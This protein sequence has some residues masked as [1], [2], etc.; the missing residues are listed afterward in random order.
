MKTG[1]TLTSIEMLKCLQVNLRK[2]RTAT[3][4][5]LNY[6]KSKNIS[7]AFVQEPYVYKTA[8][9]YYSVP[10]LGGL[11]LVAEKSVKFLSYIVFNGLSSFQYLNNF[12]SS[13]LAAASLQV[14]PRL[15]LT[16]VSV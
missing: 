9:G 10:G 6:I 5:A 8:S 11:V 12:S 3:I 15:L 16:L 1:S 2:C 7:V 14:S 13:S 4:D